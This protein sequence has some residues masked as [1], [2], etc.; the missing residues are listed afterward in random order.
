[1]LESI[2]DLN[3]SFF[4]FLSQTSLRFDESSRTFFLEDRHIQINVVHVLEEAAL[5]CAFC[6]DNLGYSIEVCSDIYTFIAPKSIP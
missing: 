4:F 6:P 3:L 1:M 2:C 5:I